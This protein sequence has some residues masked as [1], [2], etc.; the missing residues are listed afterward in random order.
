[1]YLFA[2]KDHIGDILTPFTCASL[3]GRLDEIASET[4]DTLEW[5]QIFHAT[6]VMFNVGFA[7]DNATRVVK[8]MLFYNEVPVWVTLAMQMRFDVRDVFRTEQTL[9]EPFE[10][11]RDT[12]RKCSANFEQIDPIEWPFLEALNSTKI[13]PVYQNVRNILND[14][15][16]IA[17]DNNWGRL[18][19]LNKLEDHGVLGQIVSNRD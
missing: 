1:M 4:W 2:V 17:E 6:K 5:A 7:L 14:H 10:E 3:N 18:M 12:V 11:Y 8:H 19:R 15:R 13:G 9:A 16:G